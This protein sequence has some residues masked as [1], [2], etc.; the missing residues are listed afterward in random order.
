MSRHMVRQGDKRFVFGWDPPL[1]SFFLQVHDPSLD[2]EDQ[3]IFRAGDTPETAMPEVEH[4][5]QVASEHGLWI[6]S[7]MEVHLYRE[8]DDGV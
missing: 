6:D 5:V 8:K 1:T 2:E 7:Q 3:I 4:L